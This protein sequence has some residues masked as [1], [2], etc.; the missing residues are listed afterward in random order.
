MLFQMQRCHEKE[1]IEMCYASFKT[2]Y[3][4]LPRLLSLTVL[5]VWFFPLLLFTGLNLRLFGFALWVFFLKQR[6]LT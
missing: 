3:T 6:S 2:G 1:H 5:D 4:L